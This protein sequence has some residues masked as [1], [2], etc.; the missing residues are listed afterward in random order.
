MAH[1]LVTSYPLTNVSVEAVTAFLYLQMAEQ[2]PE[3]IPVPDDDAAPEVWAEYRIAIEEQNQWYAPRGASES[4]V[5]SE[6]VKNF[7]IGTGSLLAA[8]QGLQ[9][10]GELTEE[11]IQFQFYEFAK[12]TFGTEKAEI[13]QFFLYLYQMMTN[14]PNGP[15]WGQFVMI[16]GLDNFVEKLQDRF[17]NPLR[18]GG[19]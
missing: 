11:N 14:T 12:A 5:D 18:L 10:R 4:V 7:I 13:R 2:P 17:S 3:E 16:F 9:Q 1:E 15:R 19:M 8:L 6:Q